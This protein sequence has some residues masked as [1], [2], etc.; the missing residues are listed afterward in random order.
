MAIN[1]NSPAYNAGLASSDQD[2]IGPATPAQ[3]GS[4]PVEAEIFEL[5]DQNAV[6]PAFSLVGILASNNKATFATDGDL[7]DYTALGLTA[8]EAADGQAKVA[9]YRTGVFNP[10]VVNFDDSTNGFADIEAV[11]EALR[12]KGPSLFLVEPKTGTPTIPTPPGSVT[13]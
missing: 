10:A 13:S 3:T 11:K 4:F 7:S 6:L 5:V 12:V 9:V 1:V 8:F 2:T